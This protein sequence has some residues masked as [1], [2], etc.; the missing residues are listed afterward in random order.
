[1]PKLSNSIRLD[2]YLVDKLNCSRTKA[3]DL[4]KNG[5]VLINNKVANKQGIFVTETDI[6]KINNE[7]KK[8]VNLID[9]N[10]TPCKKPL[11]IVYE[12]EYLMVI[13]K[14]KQTLVHPTTHNEKDTIANRLVHYLGKFSDDKVRPGIVHRLDKNTSGLLVVAKTLK[15]LKA[16][17]EQLVDKTLSRSYVAIC[18]GH[19]DNHHLIIKAP[20]MRCLDG[21]T[22]MMVSDSY[23]AKPAITHVNLL[24]N[25]KNDLAYVECILET[26]RTHQIRVHLKYINHPIYNDDLYGNVEAK[27][28]YG[29]YLHAYKISFIHPVT[30]KHL[31]FEA[32]PDKTF[33]NLIK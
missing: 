7:D 26:G 18:H 30:K 10:L 28:D 17:Q 8:E 11:D 31:S 33:L 3:I 4:I 22:K 24:K 27:K 23:K 14:P 20:I 25:L 19:F 15:V 16:L 5:C 2:K 13:N 32:K 29:Q 12:D 9:V 1:M 6:I 21:T